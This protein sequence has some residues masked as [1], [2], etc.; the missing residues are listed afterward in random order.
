MRVFILGAADPEMREIANV[1]KAAGER[2]AFA[3]KDGKRVHSGNAYDANELSWR[4]SPRAQVIYVE[5]RVHGLNLRQRGIVDHH[6]P[7]DPGY[8][9]GPEDYLRGSSLGQVLAMLGKSPT[10]LQRIICAAD[11]CPAS[12]YQGKCHGVSVDAFSAWRI[13]SKAE[14]KKISVEEMTARLNAQCEVLK[15]AECINFAGIEVRWVG[16]C[17]DE[18]PD[19][20]ARCGVAV[21]YQMVDRDGRNKAGILNAPS[22]VIETWMQ[23]C[24][25]KDVYGNPSRGYAGGYF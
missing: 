4:V 19:A 7:G 1:L 10:E 6:N 22:H 25:L 8:D 24:N 3:Y 9:C 16:S 12:A 5:C 21:M 11:H 15:T 17:T 23:E 18:M 13:A 2:F 20:S 14:A